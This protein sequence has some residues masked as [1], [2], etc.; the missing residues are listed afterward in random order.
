[1]FAENITSTKP[2]QH[3][4]MITTPKFIHATQCLKYYLNIFRVTYKYICGKYDEVYGTHKN[5][6]L[7]STSTYLIKPSFNLIKL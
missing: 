4:N 7:I 5:Y 6:I 2:N 1:M 3:I